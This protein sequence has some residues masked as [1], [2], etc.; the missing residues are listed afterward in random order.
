MQLRRSSTRFP[1]TTLF[2][3]VECRRDLG[4][5]GR[6]AGPDLRPHLVRIQGL[7]VEPR[8]AEGVGK[9]QVGGRSVGIVALCAADVDQALKQD[10]K[11]P[12][13]NSTHANISYAVL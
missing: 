7:Q 1:Y 10:R 4:H 2:R 8:L 13:L 3:S 11:S 6:R 12:R 9:R 5:H